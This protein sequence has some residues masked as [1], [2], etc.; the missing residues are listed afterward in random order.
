[1]KWDEIAYCD[2]HEFDALYQK[3]RTLEETGISEAAALFYQVALMLVQGPLFAS[4]PEDF[5]EERV[6]LQEKVQHA[7]DFLSR[8]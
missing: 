4:L 8:C 6:R 1:L 5:Q 7:R 2:L 3:A